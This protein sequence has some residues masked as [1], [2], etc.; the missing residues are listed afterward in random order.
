MGVA[1]DAYDVYGSYKQMRTRALAKAFVKGTMR[2]GQGGAGQHGGA[3]AP[4]PME[5]GVQ[6]VSPF[7]D[8]PSPPPG[9]AAAPPQAA[10][11]PQ[12]QI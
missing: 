1:V 7:E 8:S 9:Y 10:T 11:Q 3:Q 12:P 6:I 2:P 4:M 5:E